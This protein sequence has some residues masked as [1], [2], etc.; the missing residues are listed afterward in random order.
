MRQTANHYFDEALQIN[1]FLGGLKTQ[2]KLMLDVLV[3]GK[4]SL[5]T[6]IKAIEIMENL[7]SNANEFQNDRVMVPS[8]RLLEVNTQDGLL[9]KQKLL[10]RQ[11]KSLH[12]KSLIYLNN[13]SYKQLPLLLNSNVLCVNHVEE[14]MQ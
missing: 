5:K 1:I 4:I 13:S 10:T 14:V 2:S 12:N 6:P 8:K 7:T 9:A 3:G 11:I